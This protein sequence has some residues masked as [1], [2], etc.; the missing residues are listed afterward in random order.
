MKLIAGFIILMLVSA[1]D[2]ILF[3]FNS[4]ET[5]GRWYVV[6]DDVMGGISESKIEL[7]QDGTATFSGNLSLENN[8]GFA[9]VRAMVDLKSESSFEGVI[10]RVKGDGKIYSLR[11]RTDQNFDG[12]AYQAKIETKEDTWTEIKIPFSDFKPTFRGRTLSNKPPLTSENIRQIGILIADSQIGNFSLDVDWI[13]F[14]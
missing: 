12:Y 10:V 14:Y 9:S 5:S 1:G 13:K 7:N 3:D 2:T 6:N 11:F 4:S 8:G